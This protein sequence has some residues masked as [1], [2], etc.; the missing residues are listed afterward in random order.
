MSQVNL[1]TDLF[2]DIFSY[3]VAIDPDGPFTLR[4]VCTAWQDMVL[5]K[6]LLWSWINLDDEIEDIAARVVTCTTLSASHSLNLI[7]HLPV[8]ASLVQIIHPYVHRV[9]SVLVDC[10][11]D[12]ET[13]TA[14][15]HVSNLI[16]VLKLHHALFRFVRG[17]KDTPYCPANVYKII[18]KHSKNQS[19]DSPT[20]P[21]NMI[22]ALILDEDIHQFSLHTL[23]T[24]L[25]SNI[26]LMHME[27]NFN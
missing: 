1:N 17:G 20:C 2:Y 18:E 26:H 24:W 5:N 23:L 19:L 14:A 27:I 7:L 16:R 15:A 4:L 3:F 13:D 22:T 6:P 12:M 25:S 8:S 9:Q 10:P 21:S 11:M